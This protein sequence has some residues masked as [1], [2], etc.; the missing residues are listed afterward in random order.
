MLLN[1]F[2]GQKKEYELEI[3]YYIGSLFPK[4]VEILKLDRGLQTVSLPSWHEKFLHEGR[5]LGKVARVVS[6]GES[7]TD[8][9]AK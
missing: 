1:S 4:C 3:V 7:F 8:F 5:A 6:W 9:G 2:K